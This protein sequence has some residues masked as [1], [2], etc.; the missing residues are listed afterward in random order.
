MGGGLTE[1][2]AVSA[3]Q[4]RAKK[5]QLQSEFHA[6]GLKRSHYNLYSMTTRVLSIFNILPTRKWKKPPVVWQ[7]SD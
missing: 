5:A 2:S 4:E 3:H 6:N 1:L 7:V